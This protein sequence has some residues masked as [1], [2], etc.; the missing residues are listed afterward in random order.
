M[1]ITRPNQVWD[2]D[3][4]CLPMACGSLYLVVVMD[5]HS[6]YV[7]AW[8]LSNTRCRYSATLGQGV[9]LSSDYVTLSEKRK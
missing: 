4:T 3:I 7:L 9:L 1:R 6:R 2:A 8:W 5:W